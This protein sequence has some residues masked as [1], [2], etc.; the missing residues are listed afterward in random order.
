MKVFRRTPPP[1]PAA[2]A[3]A[4]TRLAARPQPRAHL[5]PQTPTH[6]EE[7]EE[8]QGG[9]TPNQQPPT[10]LPRNQPPPDHPRPD[11][12]RPDHPRPDH[13]RPDHP[14]TDAPRTDR[15]GPE[16]A[17]GDPSR[18]ELPRL[19]RLRDARWT[20]APRHIAVLAVLLVLGLTWVAWTFLRARPE[21]IP[22]TRPTTAT[23]GSP[24]AQPNPTRQQPTPTQPG[25]SQ[26]PQ[27]PGATPTQPPVVVHVAGKVRRPGLIK[28]PPGSRVADVLTLAGGPLRG[29]DLTSLNLARQVTDGEQ[30]IV[31]QPAPTNQLPSP[32]PPDPTTTPNTPVN[33]NTAT[34]AELDALP[35][36]GPVLAQ[37]I[38]DYRTQ[39]GPFTTVDQLRE[40]PGVGPKKFDS[41]RPH[42]RT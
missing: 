28:A 36:V 30:I 4:L 31:G 6:P 19:D 39:N 29:V 10:H 16:D 27:T 3:R 37:R 34:L 35:G 32:T 17:R 1:T 11:D 21:P 7:R 12:Q 20:L 25:A 8:V 40:V 9:W 18:P 41:L 33:L 42:V 5:H 14:H 13:P 38:L 22:D 2:R 24:V 26:S 15:L 23:A